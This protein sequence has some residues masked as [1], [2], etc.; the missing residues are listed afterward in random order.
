MKRAGIIILIIGLFLVP[1]NGFG[2]FTVT[3]KKLAGCRDRFQ[4]AQQEALERRGQK[5]LD[6]NDALIQ[7]TVRAYGGNY[8]HQD[9]S[10]VLIFREKVY[11]DFSIRVV[12]GEY[13]I[14]ETRDGTYRL[15]AI[16]E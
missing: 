14:L 5:I 15:K 12:N 11:K 10:K 13:V 4:L 3:Q 1:G 6:A 8:F 16:N 2:E 7:R 9:K